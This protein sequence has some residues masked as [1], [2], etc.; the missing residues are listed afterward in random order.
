MGD[1]IGLQ[2][3]PPKVIEDVIPIINPVVD[4]VAA[5]FDAIVFILDIVTYLIALSQ[6]V[7]A[8]VLNTVVDILQK[9][10]SAIANIGFATFVYTPK[11]F[12]PQHATGYKGFLDD[13]YASLN[14]PGDRAKPVIGNNPF[15]AMCLLAG[16]SDLTN[17][18]EKLKIFTQLFQVDL[19]TKFASMQTRIVPQALFC[20]IIDPPLGQTGFPDTVIALQRATVDGKDA[21]EITERG[22]VSFVMDNRIVEKTVISKFDLSSVSLVVA[23]PDSSDPLKTN[24]VPVKAGSVVTDAQG[25][26]SISVDIETFTQYGRTSVFLA[27]VEVDS[28]GKFRSVDLN[29]NVRIGAINLLGK[30]KIVGNSV[31]PDW[32]GFML[33]TWS[34]FMDFIQL[35]EQGLRKFKVS[36]TITDGIDDIK[37]IINQIKTDLRALIDNIKKISKTLEEMLSALSAG[38]NFLWI[39]PWPTIV[40]NKAPFKLT[41][42]DE[43]SL[44]LDPITGAT[45]PSGPG[46]SKITFQATKGYY[47]G[48][49]SVNFNIPNGTSFNAALYIR[50]SIV[51]SGSATE[52]LGLSGGIE[53]PVGVF[54]GTTVSNLR[55]PTAPSGV[56]FST[57][58]KGIQA[59]TSS[60]SILSLINFPTVY[61]DNQINSN[62]N[63]LYHYPSG[64]SFKLSAWSHLIE[65]NPGI[66]NLLPLLSLSSPKVNPDNSLTGSPATSFRILPAT[67]AYVT[68]KTLERTYLP[69]TIT[70]LL[71]LNTLTN[72]GVNQDIGSDAR[73]FDFPDITSFRA[74]LGIKNLKLLSGTARAKLGLLTVSEAVG[75]FTGQNSFLFSS[76][77]GSFT[78]S[79]KSNLIRI[80][81]GTLKSKLAWETAT[82]SRNILAGTDSRYFSWVLN[83]GFQLE[84]FD[85]DDKLLYSGNVVVTEAS[86]ARKGNQLALQ[87]TYALRALPNTSKTE[88]CVYN[89]ATGLFKF[90]FGPTA[91]KI[92]VTKSVNPSQDILGLSG[93]S[94]G[95]F[96]LTSGQYNGS[97]PINYIANTD[98]LEFKL[99]NES[100]SVELTGKYDGYGL[101][102]ALQAAIRLKT[103]RSEVVTYNQST[104]RFQLVLDP[105]G[106]TWFE[107]KLISLDAYDMVSAATIISDLNTKL[108]AASIPG[109]FAFQSDNFQ[110]LSEGMSSITFTAETGHTLKMLGIAEGVHNSIDIY[111][112]G[113]VYPFYFTTS[114]T[115]LNLKRNRVNVTVDITPEVQL[116]AENIITQIQSAISLLTVSYVSK[117]FVF[118]VNTPLYLFTD[119]LITF[120]P[121]QVLTL[122]D[123]LLS[124]KAQFDV[125]ITDTLSEFSTVSSKLKIYYPEMTVLTFTASGLGEDLLPILGLQAA[126]ATFVE[127]YTGSEFSSFLITSLTNDFSLNLGSKNHSVI[128]SN[129]GRFKGSEV[130][131]HVVFA[132][133]TSVDNPPQITYNPDNGTF[134]LTMSPEGY[135]QIDHALLTLTPS[136]TLISGVN[137]ALAL[138]TGIKS[139]ADAV[140]L[141]TVVYNNHRFTV[142]YPKLVGVQFENVPSNLSL[143]KLYGFSS[144]YVIAVN[145]RIISQVPAQYFVATPYTDFVYMVSGYAFP[146]TMA[147]STDYETGIELATR[148]TTEINL[149]T[150]QDEVLEYNPSTYTFTLKPSSTGIKFIDEESIVLPAQN[151]FISPESLASLISDAFDVVS[152]G[153]NLQLTWNGTS[154]SFEMDGLSSIELSTGSTGFNLLDF[155]GF[156]TG[157]LNATLDV[158]PANGNLKNLVITPLCNTLSLLLGNNTHIISLSPSTTI[159]TGE[160]YIVLL[161][162]AITSLST[163]NTTVEYNSTTNIFSIIADPEGEYFIKDFELTSFAN[164]T[165]QSPTQIA[166]SLSGISSA[167]GALGVEKFTYADSKFTFDAVASRLMSIE[168]KTPSVFDL[169]SAFGF[170]NGVNELTAN[171]FTFE[172]FK[173]YII[174][175]NEN[176][177]IGYNFNGF[178]GT[179][180]IPE[181]IY[182]VDISDVLTSLWTSN[183][184]FGSINFSQYKLTVESNPEGYKYFD[185]PITFTSAFS[186]T[187]AALA[188][189]IQDKI[190]AVS[191][192]G[193]ESVTYQNAA[194]K[195]L[196]TNILKAVFSSPNIILPYVLQIIGLTEDNEFQADNQAIVFDEVAPY[197][198]DND[199]NSFD[200]QLDTF[201]LQTITLDS[202]NTPL[203]GTEVAAIIQTRL[204]HWLVGTCYKHI[205]Y[206][207]DPSIVDAAN[208]I[209]FYPEYIDIGVS[210]FNLDPLEKQLKTSFYQQIEQNKQDTMN[211]IFTPPQ[212]ELGQIPALNTIYTQIMGSATAATSAV[213]SFLQSL[214]YFQFKGF[215]DE[216]LRLFRQNIPMYV[217]P[218]N[219]ND[220]KDIL[221]A[222]LQQ[223]AIN[224]GLSVGSVNPTLWDQIKQQY[225]DITFSYLQQLF[226]SKYFYDITCEFDKD[227]GTFKITS[228][229]SGRAS[230]VFIT[231]SWEYDLSASLGLEDGVLYIGTGNVDLIHRVTANELATLVLEKKYASYCWGMSPFTPFDFVYSR[232][233]PQSYSH[234]H[235][236]YH[237]DELPYTCPVIVHPTSANSGASASISAADV[238]NSPL[239]ELGFPTSA[240]GTSGAQGFTGAFTKAGTPIGITE[241]SFVFA[242][243][244]VLVIPGASDL[245]EVYN[246]QIATPIGLPKYPFS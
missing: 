124:L 37:S 189:Y 56:K 157:T 117:C 216:A 78:V 22:A 99:G 35:M 139:L 172:Q 95:T 10:I 165:F 231:P 12:E 183:P 61:A 28:T 75:T 187:G 164:G 91:E 222:Q 140:G 144:A 52:T 93:L 170:S 186:G 122:D 120:G 113:E 14:D 191:A 214:Y 235:R 89:N 62:S 15:F 82:Y 198:I 24:V 131:Q 162:T 141:E 18:S 154:F 74:S 246:N 40:S 217:D 146:I 21:I 110:F 3:A 237:R 127:T 171:K 161:Q 98:T 148:I 88:F 181:G 128:V 96:T 63:L 232:V 57:Y 168:I 8:T 94:E 23:V 105:V 160:E 230:S 129:F 104:G 116:N 132:L 234:P 38:I 49:N 220:L 243:V 100:F 42:G 240:T 119:E 179:I 125:Y 201:Q 126:T 227:H 25:K 80:I 19:F 115:T 121:S 55:I 50:K 176:D 72:S 221:Y 197:T 213:T 212:T 73:I 178:T 188:L 203:K 107:D 112:G 147:D 87:L 180:T 59:N 209:P 39:T 135:T 79:A 149:A 205:L 34:P 133:A 84:V 138:E 194:L 199:H 43:F 229:C 109:T 36:M 153:A 9:L 239:G 86:E 224:Q 102:S 97:N 29:Y 54:T 45:S 51:S 111:V 70:N 33:R 90:Y 233:I 101:A 4:A 58:G 1:W 145:N 81:T 195:L 192:E 108:V 136:A 193:D 218:D 13:L 150:S 47:V 44:S 41:S 190:R 118:T 159:Y 241:K 31:P 169:S 143:L 167:T 26:T 7:L 68:T 60:D 151:G 206:K 228:P 238:T 114:D 16:V 185:N 200:I 244:M 92:K 6:D 177:I 103:L 155:I 158:I 236:Y 173:M 69:S 67:S 27:Y 207:Y 30:D 11:G 20:G 48:T 65:L 142:A 53:S 215:S 211:A 5:F 17:I 156:N 204:R 163:R 182:D 175:E 137:A 174:K 77:A 83:A 76:I 196:K 106:Y 32:T 71:S 85:I 2:I 64:A 210:S 130:A 123:V 134:I 242:L 225:T 152:P 184:E 223:A 66:Q 202:V 46:P 226:T 219:T 166:T 208:F 245:L